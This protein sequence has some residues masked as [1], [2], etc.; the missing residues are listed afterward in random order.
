[1]ASFDLQQLQELSLDNIGSWPR[2]VKLI[3]SVFVCA[4]VAGLFY[5]FVINDTLAALSQA[6]AQETELQQAYRSKVMLSERL[7]QYQE[8]H[9]KM[10]VQLNKLLNRLPDKDET[11]AL[12]DELTY[13]G[14]SSG[15]TIRRINWQPD[16]AQDFYVELPIQMEVEGGYHQLGEFVTRIAVLPRIITL[17]DFSIAS[18]GSDQLAVSLRA[19]TYRYTGELV[20]ASK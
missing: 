17:H 9:A 4:G 8:H 7:E 20:E 10:E 16:V 5:Y 18:R 3:F 11:A 1:M 19:K 14:I 15:L 13:H 6:R 12:L 2:V